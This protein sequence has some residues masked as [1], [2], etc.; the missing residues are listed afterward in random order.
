[1][2][3]SSQEDGAISDSFI[4][5]NYAILIDNNEN[6]NPLAHCYYNVNDLATFNS[7]TWSAGAW[8]NFNT[9]SFPPQL[10]ELPEP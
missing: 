5:D 10:T 8:S 9:T 4:T 1:M 6:S 2:I 7:K 3:G